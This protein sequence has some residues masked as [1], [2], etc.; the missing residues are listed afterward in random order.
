MYKWGKYPVF[1]CIIPQKNALVLHCPNKGQ[2]N[3]ERVLNPPFRGKLLTL[4][5]TLSDPYIYP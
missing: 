4:M 5:L 3:F 2:K 1:I